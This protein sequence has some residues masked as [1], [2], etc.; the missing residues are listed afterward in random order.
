MIEAQTL[1]SFDNFFYYGKNDFNTEIESDLMQV[2]I[3]PKRSMLYNRQFGAGVSDRENYPNAISLQ[4]GLRFDI[5]NAIAYR[6]G[7]VSDGE[8]DTRDRRIAASQ[9][10]LEFVQNAGNLDIRI[11]YFSFANT[12]DI[13]AINLSTGGAL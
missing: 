7:V 8:N 9:F 6:N 1:S 2:A 5:A 11:Y 13:R 3:Q 10:S 12:K 4:I